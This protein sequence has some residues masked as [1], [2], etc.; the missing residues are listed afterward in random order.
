MNRIRK[1]DNIYQV[2]ITPHQKYNVGFEFLLGSW[3]DEALMGFIVKEYD[4]L[5][6]AECEAIQHPDIN[7]EQLVEFHKDSYQFLK[8]QI[9]EIINRSN[10]AVELIPVLLTP[11]QVKNKMFERVIKGNV[12]LRKDE[13]LSGFRTV[14][15]MNDI[16]N[17]SIVNPWSR[18]LREIASQL[19]KYGRLNIFHTL[20]KNNIL[21]LIG[22]TDIG[23]TYEIILVPSIINNW[24]HWKNINSSLS[25]SRYVGALLNCIKAQNAVDSTFIL[26]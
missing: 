7:W 11:E 15:D 24:M 26:R 2:L 21:H 20:E 10:M 18:N 22:R 16:I 3:T 23:T 1:Y 17:F 8:S 19:L 14:Y 6:E 25:P 13:T 5:Y 4:N 12:E 9:Q